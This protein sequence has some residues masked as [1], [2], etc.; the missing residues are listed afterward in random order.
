MLTRAHLIRPVQIFA[1]VSTVIVG[2]GCVLIPVGYRACM[3][4]ELAQARFQ[5]AITS[6]FLWLGVSVLSTL[7]LASLQ[8]Y[9]PLA[10]SGSDGECLLYL[11]SVCAGLIVS[12]GVVHLMFGIP[13]IAQDDYACPVLLGYGL[14]IDVFFMIVF[15][16][17]AV[18][19]LFWCCKY[20]MWQGFG[21]ILYFLCCSKPGVQDGQANNVP[22]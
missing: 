11:W 15:G 6:L 13:A 4:E 1:L 7:L 19:G 12:G 5:L 14:S 20:V 22:V 9:K 2:I 16:G 18:I 17:L 10:I 21:G 8:G 3:A